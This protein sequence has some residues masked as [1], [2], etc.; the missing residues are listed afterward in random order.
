[1]KNVTKILV[2]GNVLSISF[3]TSLM[4]GSSSISEKKPNLLSNKRSTL[5]LNKLGFTKQTCLLSNSITLIKT[6]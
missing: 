1:M 6:F 3:Y 4:K 2:F 5:L